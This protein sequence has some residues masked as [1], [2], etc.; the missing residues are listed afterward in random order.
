MKVSIMGTNGFL[1]NTIAKYCNKRGDHLDMYGL[2]EPKS[3]EFDN[4][5]N[6]DL[7]KNQLDYS[8]LIT[9]DIIVYCIGAGIQSNLK[10]SCSLIYELNVNS[11]VRICNDLKLN[12]YL[13]VFVSFGSFFEIGET[14]KRTPFTERDIINSCFPV[15][16]D[17]SVSKRM[18]SRFVDSYKH[19][20][21]HWHFFLPTIYGEGENPLRL[22]PYTINSIKNKTSIHFTSGEQ[23]RQYLYVDEVAR[24]IDISYQKK[25]Q[26]GFYNIEGTDTISVKQLV[27]LIYSYFGKQLP[28]DC[29]GTEKR[30]DV[31][32]KYLSLD[33]IKLEKLIGYKP[34]MRILSQ[35]DNYQ[36]I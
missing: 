11:P 34:S 17:Y 16:N 10:E 18:F 1:S 13:G 15:A 20:F 35:L 12:N 7:I 36:M 24:I 29:F 21:T 26:S 27:K 30:A 2:E 5:Y 19:A 4:F 32:M 25:L 33:G 14:D 3:H 6:V 8:S 22:I 23:I 28:I 31:G 9:S